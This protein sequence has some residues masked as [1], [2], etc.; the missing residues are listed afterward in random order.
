MPINRELLSVL[1][2][3]V[4]KL[5]VSM[6]DAEKLDLLNRLVS[7][8]KIHTMDGNALES[9]LSEALIT[10]NGNM[11]YRIDDGIPIML[12]DQGIAT[13]QMDNN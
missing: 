6:L 9:P 1:V 4:T 5:P 10:N 13:D 7:E 3:P 11:I 12:E 8:G 2:C